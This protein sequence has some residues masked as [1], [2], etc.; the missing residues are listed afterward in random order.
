MSDLSPSEMM[1]FSMFETPLLFVYN[2]IGGIMNLQNLKG[3]GEKT[4]E[5]L[6]KANIYTL[7][8]LLTYYPY[9]YQVLEPN[10]LEETT[11]DLTI[12]INAKVIDPGKV[13][14]IRR[15]FNSYRFKVESYGKILTV[16]IFNRA[17]L[18]K[19]MTIGREITLIGK[20]NA[21]KNTF[22]AQD[23]KLSKLEGTKIIPVY[24][25]IKNI[26]NST[27]IKL[28]EEALKES[29]SI[30][31]YIPEKYNAKYQF[32][33]KKEALANIHIPKDINKIKRAKQKLIYEELFIFMFKIQYL[34]ALKEQ[35]V[36]IEKRFSE[37][38]VETFINNLPFSLTKDQ[39]KAISEGMKD[40]KSPKRMNR[41]LL[42]DVGSGKTIVATTLMYANFLAG[43]QSAFMAPTEILA[44]Q[45]YE[46][47]RN[48][49]KNTDI[50]IDY[51]IG[52]MS[53]KEKEKIAEKVKDGEI[54]ILV[55]THAIL[56]ERLYF[57]NLG[58][59]ITDE[60]HRF[61][62][63]QRDILT[64]KGIKPDMMF[65][66][67]TPIPR[68]YALTIYGDMDTSL[69]KEKP[70]GRK[71]IT[72]KVVKEK[73]LKEVLFKVL[74]A[75]KKNEQ[76]YVV[77][78]MIEENTENDLKDVYL[79]KE[80]FDLAFHSKIPIGILHGKLKKAEKEEVM[81]DFKIGRTKI[82]ISTTVVEVGVDV[83]NATIMI[84]FNAERFGLATLHQLRGRVGRNDKQSYCYLI[85]NE[86]KERLKV[87]EESNDGFYI[88]EKDF[89]FRGEGDLFGVKQSGDMT[90]KI[91][92]LKR[93]YNILIHAKEDVINYIQSEDYRSEKKYQEIVDKMNFTN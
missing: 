24:H 58:L 74:E 3:I 81:N 60:Q 90:F 66:S 26:K 19:N 53:K 69:I 50:H 10:S 22:T 73:D 49:V 12:T 32:I 36:G 77:A 45:H 38:K 64:Q 68:T 75:V 9:R 88:S 76:V 2:E 13:S 70:A 83:K 82:L 18:K 15:N 92:N 31:D 29:A 87:L 17:F 44:L 91:A 7:E 65:M 85:C 4:I 56:N 71:E 16:T 54:D 47:I 61:G 93:D 21:K 63:N 78:P 72:T 33:T 43:Y 37:E 52:S 25:V 67:A 48:V 39:E 8:D 57:Q 40:M 28:I 1:D 89:E 59:I 35:E 30:E 5:Y 14:F 84:I 55:G 80:K 27:L 42:G 41:L 23:M 79:L 6:Y 34:K 62:V 46:S 20:Y 86:E 11:E 51:L